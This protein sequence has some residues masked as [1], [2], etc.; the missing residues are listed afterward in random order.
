MQ[1][2]NVYM[3]GYSTSLVIMEMQ[4]KTSMRYHCTPVRIKWKRLATPSVGEEEEKL[5]FS[6]TADGNV[7]W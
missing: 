3:K 1:V 4:I 6:Y 7:K 2:E 5:G